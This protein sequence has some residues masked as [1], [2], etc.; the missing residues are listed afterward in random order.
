LITACWRPEIGK[1]TGGCDHGVHRCNSA[2]I[3]LLRGHDYYRTIT[4]YGVAQL[5]SPKLPRRRWR[6]SHVATATGTVITSIRDQIHSPVRSFTF[7]WIS[8]AYQARIIAT[9]ANPD[10]RIAGGELTELAI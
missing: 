9:S 2:R 1:N 3:I 4:S 6:S 5:G 7:P 8:S 10:A